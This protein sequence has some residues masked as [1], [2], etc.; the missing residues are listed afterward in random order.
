MKK[1]FKF[2][3]VAL[4]ALMALG[5][6]TFAS[7]DKEN[8]AVNP[9]T[10]QVATKS[11]QFQISECFRDSMGRYWNMH[12]TGSWVNVNGGRNGVYLNVN[13]R[14]RGDD[15]IYYYKGQAVWN[16]TVD[17]VQFTLIPDGDEPSRLVWFVMREYSKYLLYG[18]RI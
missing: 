1:F 14:Q 15:A 17:P 13:F 11:L 12:G 10:E 6:L 4:A 5:S 16:P 3:S 2:Y 8:D 18:Q 9:Q 7:C